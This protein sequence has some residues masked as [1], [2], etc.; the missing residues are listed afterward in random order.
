MKIIILSLVL[1]FS[2]CITN[3]SNQTINLNDGTKIKV[4]IDVEGSN[5]SDRLMQVTYR[6]ENKNT[7]VKNIESTVEQIFEQT[8]SI[9]EKDEIEEIL[10]NYEYPSGATNSNGEPVYEVIIS[11]ASRSENSK[12]NLTRSNY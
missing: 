10:I 6:S 12:W 3:N 1:I 2:G 7:T 11:E 5:Q 8:K 4:K 9:A